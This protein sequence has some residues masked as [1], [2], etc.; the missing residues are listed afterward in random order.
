MRLRAL[1]HP[2]AHKRSHRPRLMH[3]P[4]GRCA[5]PDSA[6]SFL[7]FGDVNV[8][9][10]AVF[11]VLPLSGLKLSL[12]SMMPA[13]RGMLMNARKDCQARPTSQRAGN[14]TLSSV[15]SRA[16]SLASIL[17]VRFALGALNVSSPFTINWACLSVVLL[18]SGQF[19]LTPGKSLF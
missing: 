16:S 6:S 1:L 14:L 5:L 9:H 13:R 4:T 18:A 19:L 3:S 8:P 12:D 10:A 7:A 2:F 11:L 15:E 17:G